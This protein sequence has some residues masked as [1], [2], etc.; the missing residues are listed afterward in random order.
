MPL[1]NW[2]GVCFGDKQALLL[3]IGKIIVK[4]TIIDNY[5]LNES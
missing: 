1:M 5:Y 3:V 2:K 4:K